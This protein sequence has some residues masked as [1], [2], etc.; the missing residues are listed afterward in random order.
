MNYSIFSHTWI[1]PLVLCCEYD[2]LSY[3]IDTALHWNIKV[4]C[5]YSSISMMVIRVV[6]STKL[7]K[8]I[9]KTQF[10]M[11]TFFILVLYWC[12][13]VYYS[14]FVL[15]IVSKVPNVSILWSFIIV[16]WY[17]LLIA[18]DQVEYGGLHYKNTL[19]EWN[20]L[21]YSTLSHVIYCTLDNESHSNKYT[22]CT[23]STL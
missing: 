7:S 9:L 6:A 15:R 5:Y 22:C 12:T 1:F 21:P 17:I 10:I 19:P 8:R 18:R 13:V 14:T 2:R 23:C 20:H 16:P 3:K 4:G 11:R